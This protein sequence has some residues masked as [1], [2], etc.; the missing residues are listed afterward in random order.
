MRRNK[1]KERGK[2]Q[3]LSILLKES[4]KF[5]PAA[6]PSLPHTSVDMPAYR[7]GV[8]SC[9]HIVLVDQSSLYPGKSRSTRDYFLDF[10]LTPLHQL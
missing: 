4:K 6:S 7:Y 5:H 9:L 8:V 1:R 2:K 3:Q 10:P